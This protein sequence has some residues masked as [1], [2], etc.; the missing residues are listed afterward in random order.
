MQIGLLAPAARLTATLSRIEFSLLAP[1]EGGGL[2]RPH[3]PFANVFR[4]LHA[5][6][7]SVAFSFLDTLVMAAHRAH[8]ALH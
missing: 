1:N 5:K 4:R 6:V 8:L 2:T 7:A 3:I